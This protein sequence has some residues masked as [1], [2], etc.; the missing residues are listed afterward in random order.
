MKKNYLLENIFDLCLYQS[1][2]FILFL[3]YY[4]FSLCLIISSVFLF[5]YLLLVYYFLYQL[6]HFSSFMCFQLA[7]NNSLLC[8]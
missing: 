4:F 1:Y 5:Y 8:L 3:Y 2:V 6:F 7:Y